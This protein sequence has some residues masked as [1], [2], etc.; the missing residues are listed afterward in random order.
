M[1]RNR[2]PT[3]KAVWQP[4]TQDPEVVMHQRHA[5]L[6]AQF[7]DIDLDGILPDEVW[8]NDRYTVTV[9]YLDDDRDGPVEVGIHNNRRTIHIPWRHLQQIKNE[10]L[11]P[12]RE[13]IQAHPAESRLVDT[14][15]EFWLWAY[16][17][18]TGPCWPN[19]TPVGFTGDRVIDYEH[20]GPARPGHARQSPPLIIADQTP[21]TSR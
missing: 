20:V 12:E 5:A 1:A 11:G 6:R 15:N 2:K 18:G 3:P 19:G 10:V 8:G 16:P 17:T 7:P 4:L 9:R 13:A 21:T 14:A